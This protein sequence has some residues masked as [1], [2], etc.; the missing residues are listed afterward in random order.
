MTTVSIVQVE[1]E[2]KMFESEITTELD[3]AKSRCFRY[4]TSR[5][6]VRIKDKST[7]TAE[8]NNSI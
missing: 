8:L 5:T 3:C 7:I 4:G 6:H 2:M 1:L